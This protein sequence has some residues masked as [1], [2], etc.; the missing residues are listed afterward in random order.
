MTVIQA[1]TRFGRAAEVDGR[2]YVG[3]PEAGLNVLEGATLRPLPGPRARQR[4][5]SIVLR[6][7]T[8]RRLLVGTR[9]NGLFLYD[10]AAL[11]PFATRRTRRSRHAALSRH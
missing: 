1:T 9:Q 5:V 11:T 3:T 2:V 4:A 6:D 10:G 7:T 8:T